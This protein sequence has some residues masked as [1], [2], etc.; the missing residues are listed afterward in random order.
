MFGRLELCAE[1]GID[2]LILLLRVSYASSCS[3][4]NIDGQRC[5]DGA[6]LVLNLNGDS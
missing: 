2:N 3:L 1:T 4:P 6:S 5:S